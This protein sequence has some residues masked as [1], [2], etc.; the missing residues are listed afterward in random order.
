M[1]V[2]AI[3]TIRHKIIEVEHITTIIASAVHEQGASTQEIAR[4]VRS[5]ASGT[6]SMSEHVENVEAAVMETGT[7]V[8]SVV[9]LAH[10]LD[11]MAARMRSRV[12]AFTKVLT[13]G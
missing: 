9:E 3:E 12:E 4:N 1:S 13:A 7:N 2:E 8:E 11:A 6:T 5:A 10:K